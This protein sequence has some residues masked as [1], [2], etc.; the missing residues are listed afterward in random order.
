MPELFKS[1]YGYSLAV[2]DPGRVLV[3]QYPM[4]GDFVL[5]SWRLPGSG[6]PGV[7]QYTVRWIC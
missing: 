5:F 4:P 6:P 3:N 7:I 1:G 2:S